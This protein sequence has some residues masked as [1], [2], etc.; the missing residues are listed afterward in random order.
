[1]SNKIK[2][3]TTQDNYTLVL[4]LI[5]NHYKLDLKFYLTINSKTFVPCSNTMIELYLKS[6]SVYGSLVK[7]GSICA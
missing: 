6:V 3:Y 2:V 7:D 4:A 5:V 1:M